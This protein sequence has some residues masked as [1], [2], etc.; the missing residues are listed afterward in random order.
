MNFSRK[1]HRFSSLVKAK[2]NDPSI[3]QV[4]SNFENLLDAKNAPP[5]FL[6]KARINK[7]KAPQRFILLTYEKE[8]A[9]S[10]LSRWIEDGEVPHR[11]SIP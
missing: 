5:L 3:R 4:E 2:R 11:S 6:A 9:L 8:S 7:G 1:N 10:P